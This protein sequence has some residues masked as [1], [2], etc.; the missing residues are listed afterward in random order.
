MI[1][2]RP[3][4]SQANEYFQSHNFLHILANDGV[5]PAQVDKLQTALRTCTEEQVLVDLRGD[6]WLMQTFPDNEGRNI[7]MAIPVS[8]T[9]QETFASS[10]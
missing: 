2:L 6:T 7:V 3:S 10:G 8:V 5:D 9:A 4:E 1:L